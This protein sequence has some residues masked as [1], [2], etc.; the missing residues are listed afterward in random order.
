MKKNVLKWLGRVGATLLTTIVILVVGLYGVMAML[1]WG[2]SK[3]AKKQFIM[4][5]QE[6][7]E[8]GFMANWFCSQEEIDMIKEENSV[9]DTTDIT[10]SSLVVIGQD[11]SSDEEDLYVVDVTWYIV[12]ES[13]FNI[14]PSTITSPIGIA[15]CGVES[16]NSPPLIPASASYLCAISATVQPF[17]SLNSGTVPTN[18]LE[19]SLTTISL[20]LYVPAFT[21]TT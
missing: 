19:G 18:N 20:P 21:S 16:T 9:K 1:A 11:S 15:V 5:L 8:L 3:V 7:G 4:S 6:T 13:P 12:D 17:S 14:L 2:P 10:D